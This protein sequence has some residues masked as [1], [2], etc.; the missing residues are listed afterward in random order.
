M[1][2]RYEP[3]KLEETNT[4]PKTNMEPKKMVVWVDVSP[5]RKAVFSGSSRSFSGVYAENHPK[6]SFA[7]R[8]QCSVFLLVEYMLSPRDQ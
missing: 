7:Y 5:F 1:R 2:S 4:P 6:V 3:K 8:S